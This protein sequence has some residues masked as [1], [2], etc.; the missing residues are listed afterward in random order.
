MPATFAN[1]VASERVAGLAE[2][3]AEIVAGVK[4]R[5][6]GRF[7]KPEWLH[8]SG[9]LSKLP[10]FN[11]EMA[12]R[13]RKRCTL[14]CPSWRIARRDHRHSTVQARADAPIAS[15]TGRYKRTMVGWAMANEK[16]EQ[17]SQ[18]RDDCASELQ[19]EQREAGNEPD[20]DDA[21]RPAGHHSVRNNGSK[22]GH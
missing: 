19:M 5:A 11:P 9:I 1:W 12:I 18:N 14:R 20:T 10:V 13:H 21:D 6:G 17:R 4:R 22:R 15:Q 3:V 8:A 16:G 7:I 2:C